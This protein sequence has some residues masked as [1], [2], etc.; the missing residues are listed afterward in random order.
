MNRIKKQSRKFLPFLQSK[1]HRILFIVLN[2]YLIFGM[3]SLLVTILY[4]VGHLN[5]SDSI[6]RYCIPGFV[7]GVT[8][9]IIYYIGYNSIISE[10][11]DIKRMHI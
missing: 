10:Q 5:Q 9:A 6:I 3:C 1:K 2:I 8:S 11:G 7:L 4:L